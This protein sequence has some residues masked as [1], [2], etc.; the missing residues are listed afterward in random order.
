MLWPGGAVILPPAT[1]EL[2]LLS[3]G[4]GAREERGTGHTCGT[5]GTRVARG[6]GGEVDVYGEAPCW[7]HVDGRGWAHTKVTDGKLL[8]VTVGCQSD[9]TSLGNWTVRDDS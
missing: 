2:S 3:K 8:T 6:W 7:S 4:V 1:G 5:Q 9:L